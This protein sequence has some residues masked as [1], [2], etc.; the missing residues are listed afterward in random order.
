MANKDV[1][2]VIS[3]I[4]KATQPFKKIATNMTSFK[5]SINNMQ[6]TF[7][8]MAAVWTTAFAGLWLGISSAVEK[9]WNLQS[10][11]V[12]LKS[13]VQG[14]WWD[15]DKAKAFLN[16]FTADWLV[17]MENAATS[18]KNLLSKWFS[19]DEATQMMNRF[20]DSSAFWRQAALSMWEAVQSATEWIKNENSILVDNAWVT[21][22]ISVMQEEYA[23]KLWIST[24]ALTDAQKN[25]AIYQWVLKET[26]FQ[27]WDA[28]KAS[29]WY[30][31]TVAQ[32]DAAKLKL[33]Q[34]IWEIFMPV[35][36]KLFWQ[37]NSVITV[38]Q[39]WTEQHPT[40]TK[41]LWEWAIAVAW[42]VT[43]MW[44]LGLLV[45]TLI[46]G[47]S[48]LILIVKGL[49]TALLF[50]TTNPIW[51]VITAI[52]ALIAIWVTLYQ[53]W[54]TVKTKAI[55]LGEFIMGLY[56]KYK[57]LF[58]V[59]APMIAAWI[60][61]VKNWDLIKATATQL[62][63]ALP[64][65]WESLKTATM[66]VFQAI[67]EGIKNVIQAAID[68]VMDK[69]QS[70]I[71]F[72]NSA[73]ETITWAF[74]KIK[75][76]WSN[77]SSAVSN[78]A[79]SVWNAISDTV[80]GARADWWAVTAWKT[81]LVW[82]RWPELF[83]PASSWWI[84]SNENLWSWTNISVNMWWV[85]VTNQQDADYLANKVIEKITRQLQLQK[86]GIS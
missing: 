2:I 16:D 80:S 44:T 84:T 73:I 25:E 5:E 15:F 75:S 43:V 21:K 32:L 41:Y 46:T 6:G 28:Q 20:K 54:D 17:P 30:Q 48:N 85:T 19:L 38:V 68:Y 67:G 4:D 22:N 79:S 1:K 3:A 9:A 34:T 70:A 31:W 39:Q 76:I 36:T 69:I 13:I 51:L 24:S 26:A 71:D 59:F 74:N 37:I 40:L 72:A 53:N 50:L 60:E 7:T 35:M 14:T 12:G 27:V 42:L 33:S 65:I 61:L 23:K 29:E 62:M 47:F 83:T 64:W 82:E 56:E 86:I 58:W 63:D 77:I 45:P 11:L 8:K 18:L 52:W 55:E 49:W 78:A 57:I 66:G 10:S 81:Y